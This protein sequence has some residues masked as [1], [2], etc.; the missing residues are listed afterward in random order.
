MSTTLARYPNLEEAFKMMGADNGMSLVDNIKEVKVPDDW[1]QR[2]EDAEEIAAR[3]KGD[4]L[5]TYLSEEQMGEDVEGD[6]NALEY[7]TDG[8]QSIVEMLV[9][10]ADAQV[11]NEILGAA[12]DG[13]LSKVFYDC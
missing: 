10:A 11:L 9:A 2:F 1:T 13:E 4:T 5:D 8:E 6:E 3:L 7:M 12:F